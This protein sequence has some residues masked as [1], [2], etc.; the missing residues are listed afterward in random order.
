MQIGPG[1]LLTSTFERCHRC[2]CFA[3]CD[4]RVDALT[5]TP[6]EAVGFDRPSTTVGAVPE[7]ASDCC[8]LGDARHALDRLRLAD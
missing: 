5:S 7:K 4:Q 3:H 2:R 1:C 6:G 8:R